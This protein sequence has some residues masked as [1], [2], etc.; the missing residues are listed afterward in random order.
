V[1]QTRQRM[2]RAWGPDR[3]ILWLSA[4]NR[5]AISITEPSKEKGLLGKAAL[6]PRCYRLRGKGTVPVAS[7]QL[8]PGNF[9]PGCFYL[10]LCLTRVPVKSLYLPHCLSKFLGFSKGA[11]AVRVARFLNPLRIVVPVKDAKV[12]AITSCGYI[13]SELRFVHARRHVSVFP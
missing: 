4:L 10:S 1:A 6:A 5:C 2:A 12:F 8:T 7:N 3:T 9:V 11:E 13:P